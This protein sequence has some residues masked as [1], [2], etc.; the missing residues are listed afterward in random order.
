MSDW[1]DRA[2]KVDAS[3]W[4]DRAEVLETPKEMGMGE[5]VGRGI[6]KSLPAAGALAGGVVGSGIGPAGTFWGGALGAAGGRAVENFGENL[7]GDT[8]TVDDLYGAPVRDAAYESVAQGAGTVIGKGLSKAGG[9]IDDYIV[10]PTKGLISRLGAP[11]KEGA[12]AL[13]AAAERIGAEP[14]RGMLTGDRFVQNVESG[15]AQ[16]AT[17]P[18][19]Q[20]SKKLTGVNDALKEAGSDVVQSGQTLETPIQMAGRTKGLM[21]KTVEDRVAP[22]VEVYKKISDETPHIKVID[23]S[24]K[25]I[26]RNIDNLPYAKIKGSPEQGFASQISNNLREVKSL[27]ELRNLRSYV[28]K[29]FNNPMS[30][31]TMRDTAGEI[32]HRL[33]K[34]EQNSITRSAIE[35]SATEKKGADV[36]KAMINEI[37]GANKI[38]SETSKDLQEIA[39]QTGMGKVRNY[40]EFLRKLENIPDERLMDKM[41]NV[42]NVKNLKKM[43]T[44]FPEA[45]DVLK[46]AKVQDLYMQS[47]SK[48]EISIPKLVNNA[49]RMSPE[50]KQLIFGPGAT[51][52]LNDIETVYNSTYQKVGPS[53][54]PEGLEFTKFN[55]FSPKSWYNQLSAKAR[56]WILENPE[57]F[58][59]SA[60]K[61]KVE[62][63]QGLID[64]KSRLKRSTAPRSLL[65]SNATPA[66]YPDVADDNRGDSA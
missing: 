59:T 31:G 58:K 7:L 47:L 34:L 28:G 6:L 54:T 35:N 29:Q 22:A 3:S 18:G 2:Q 8:K 19:Q 9:M 5:R 41:F 25:R 43:Q 52:K 40:Q 23:E 37:K 36:A 27:D 15:L 60:K 13:K 64:L 42:N 55:P 53:G 12:E 46:T 61:V 16:S 38:Y 24:T 45:F 17:E 51:Q 10:Q 50:S 44:A 66:S 65:P 14:T 33:G 63:P 30:P 32:Y 62:Q 48:G 1:K 11:E 56:E 26:S 39:I 4:K 21:N 49:R 20:M 57:K